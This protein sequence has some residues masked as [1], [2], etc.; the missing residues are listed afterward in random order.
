[1]QIEIISNSGV[2]TC[3]LGQI[4]SKVLS[5]GDV[6]L[7]TGEL[8]GGKTTF[9]SGIARGLDITGNPS[10]P[11]FTII[12]EYRVGR[13]KN[14]VHIDLYRL[15]GTGEISEIGIG[16]YIYNSNSIVCIEWGDKV[17]EYIKGDFLEINLDYLKDKDDTESK[18]K[19]LFSSSNRYWDRKL[20]ELRG[21]LG[22][23]KEWEY[24]ST[25]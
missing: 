22:K 7:F 6:I 19:I 12:N 11:S 21:I 25:F 23:N 18:R 16:D 8:G 9:I 15:E 14:L 20:E 3:K 17:K 24:N 2:S 10:S 4:F 13:F 5:G 1:M